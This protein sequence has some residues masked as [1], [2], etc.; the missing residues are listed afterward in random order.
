MTSLDSLIYAHYTYLVKPSSQEKYDY[1]FT[2]HVQRQTAGGPALL[3]KTPS[4]WSHFPANISTFLFN[5]VG[6][7]LAFISQIC[8]LS[9]TLTKQRFCFLPSFCPKLLSNI[10]IKSS[11]A[12][13]NLLKHTSRCSAKGQ[14]V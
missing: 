8:T 7:R 9:Q 6:L 14:G 2:S 13:S 1:S 12:F 11:L 3:D 4:L 5:V 10:P